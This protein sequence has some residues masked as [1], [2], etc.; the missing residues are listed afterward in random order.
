MN[1][2]FDFIEYE[3]LHELVMI[4]NSCK[5]FLLN[6]KEI[7]FAEAEEYYKNR[8]LE[9]IEKVFLVWVDSDCVGYVNFIPA[10]SEYGIKIK[11][12]YRG[13]GIGKEI[14]TKFIN[15]LVDNYSIK[16]INADVLKSNE[17]SLRLHL[18]CGFKKIG[19]DYKDKKK[20]LKMRWTK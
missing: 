6:N 19:E 14:L 15:F 4:R 12:E 11:P 16:K 2:T 7:T 1:I 8:I 17:A 13:K 20:I 10:T 3:T 9:M 18:V 5:D